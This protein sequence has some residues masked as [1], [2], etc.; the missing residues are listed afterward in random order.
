MTNAF[1]TLM[2]HIGDTGK[3][4]PFLPFIFTFKSVWREGINTG[5]FFTITPTSRQPGFNTDVSGWL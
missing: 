2:Q 5:G 4:D 3:I 1:N